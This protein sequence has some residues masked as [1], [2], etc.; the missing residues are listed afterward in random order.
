MSNNIFFAFGFQ[1]KS[2]ALKSLLL[3]I[4]YWDLEM[5]D[6][7]GQLEISEECAEAASWSHTAQSGSQAGSQ[8]GTE[9]EVFKFANGLKATL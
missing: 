1:S 9:V 8:E 3:E 2:I 7:A 4:S 6:I 5:S